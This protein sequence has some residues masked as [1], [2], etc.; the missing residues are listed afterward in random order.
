MRLIQLLLKYLGLVLGVFVFVFGTAFIGFFVSEPIA[1][2]IARVLPGIKPSADNSIFIEVV[3]YTFLLSGLL[4]GTATVATLDR[5][6][7]G[8][9][10]RPYWSSL[11]RLLAAGLCATSGLIAGGM[12][13]ASRYNASRPPPDPDS[14]GIDFM[15]DA[16]AFC[17]GAF[18]GFILMLIISVITLALWEYRRSRIES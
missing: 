11:L 8:Q 14:G 16:I 13:A 4:I 9:P 18:I 1:V 7:S 6:G 12:I 10:K 5:E 3:F 2:I 15:G 17:F